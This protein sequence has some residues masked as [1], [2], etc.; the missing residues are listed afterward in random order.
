[1]VKISDLQMDMKTKSGE[2]EE[3]I[4]AL[5][6]S[7]RIKGEFPRPKNYTIF[8]EVPVSGEYCR[9]MFTGHFITP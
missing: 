2:I 5:Q 8:L 3:E 6:K 7:T 4:S 1:M 9:N